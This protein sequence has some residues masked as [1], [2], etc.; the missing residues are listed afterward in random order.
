[1]VPTMASQISGRS[2]ALVHG[3]QDQR[4]DAAH[5]A[6]FGRR[7]D[8]GVDEGQAAHGAEHREDQHG[9]RDDAAQALAHSAQPERARRLGHARHVVRLDHA[10]MKV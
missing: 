7:G 6:G 9:R 8:G 5:R 10:S 3:G 1:M 4:A 2:Q